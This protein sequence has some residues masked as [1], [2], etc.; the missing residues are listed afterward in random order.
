MHFSQSNNARLLNF[1]TEGSNVDAKPKIEAIGVAVVIC[2][3]CSFPSTLLLAGRDTEDTEEVR[4]E[5]PQ[6]ILHVIVD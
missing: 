6:N 5:S 1:F 3:K 2:G 4:P